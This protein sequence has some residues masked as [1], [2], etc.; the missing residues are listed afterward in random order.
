MST[1][2]TEKGTSPQNP[3]DVGM[4]VNVARANWRLMAKVAAALSVV[5]AIYVYSL[6]RGYE[7]SVMLA[8]EVSASSGL[9]GSLGSMASMV[10]LDLGATMGDDAIYPEIYPDILGSRQFLVELFDITVATAD[11]SYTGTVQDYLTHHQQ[12]TWWD[13]MLRPLRKA[14][15]KLTSKPGRTRAADT[16]P[17][18]FWL[19]KDDDELCEALSDLVN[20]NVDKK[21]SVITISTRAQDALVS[22]M[23]ADSIRQRLQDYIIAY[24]TA[25]AVNDLHFFERLRQEAKEKY[26]SAVAA[27]SRYADSHKDAILQTYISERDNLE[28]EMQLAF[29]VYNQMSQQEQMARAKVQ[30]KTPAFTV[31][32]C[33]TVPQKPSSPKRV[34]TIVAAFV[35][36]LLATL[37]YLLVRPAPKAALKGDDDIPCAA[38][39]AA[40]A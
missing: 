24:R 22:A 39:A 4:I 13:N 27:Y 1:T 20:C 2:T 10:G 8:P 5:A 18:P 3:I 30:E 33:A 40:Q 14:L 7:A 35:A 36:G 26:D 16:K 15:K 11:G 34:R 31:V 32:Q 23:L 19:S 38:T 37:A 29:N 17:D 28:N 12:H 9:Q 6:P 25:K 21:T